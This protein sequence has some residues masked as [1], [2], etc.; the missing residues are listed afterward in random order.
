MEE[1]EVEEGGRKE[2]EGSR[3]ER[4]QEGE[5][6]LKKRNFLS[7]QDCK[8]GFSWFENYSE[9]FYLQVRW[10]SCYF[11]QRKLWSLN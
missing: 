9:M 4:K 10:S 6:F 1:E 11:G 3:E 2:K 8:G 5:E 7:H